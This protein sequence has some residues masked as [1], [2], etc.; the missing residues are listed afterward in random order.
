MLEVVDAEK[1]I[2]GVDWLDWS[3]WLD[4]IGDFG[5]EDGNRNSWVVPVENKRGGEHWGTPQKRHV[6]AEPIDPRCS[7][8]SAPHSPLVIAPVSPLNKCNVD[9]SSLVV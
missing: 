9:L 1:E 7:G 5:M 6:P 4:W 2:P 8:F 3:D